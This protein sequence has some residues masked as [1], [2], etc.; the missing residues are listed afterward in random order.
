M[1]TTVQI[2][3]QI[4]NVAPFCNTVGICIL[5]TLDFIQSPYLSDCILEISLY[6]PELVVQSVSLTLTAF[7]KVWGSVPTWTKAK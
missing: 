6:A 2:Q 5:E 7:Q 3:F 1:Q 4:L